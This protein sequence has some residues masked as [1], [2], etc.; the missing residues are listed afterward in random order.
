MFKKL[1]AVLILVAILIIGISPALAQ[2]EGQISGVVYIDDND[3]NSRDPG[4]DGVQFI[5]VT[6]TS[7]GWS[8]TIS[9]NESG[10]YSIDLNP[11]EWEVEILV[12]DGYTA[13]PSTK[14]VTIAN[15]GDT[16]G[17]VDFGLVAVVEDGDV[18]PGNEDDDILP[19]SGGVVSSGV[20]VSGLIG[21]MILG[22]VAVIIGQRRTRA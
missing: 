17:N 13:D 5:E 6:F 4:E 8:T 19:T 15:P 22:M 11:G 12:P 1:A 21:M 10:A 16:V 7:S 3:S 18:L 9:T 14:Q 20:I 2:S